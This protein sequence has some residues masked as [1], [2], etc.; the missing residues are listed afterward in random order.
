[1]LDVTTVDD[2]LIIR[3]GQDII[4]TMVPQF[5]A[6][7][8]DLLSKNPG[9][10]CL[11]LQNV[12]LMDSVGIGVLIAIHNTLKKQGHV[13]AISNASENIAKLFQTMRL[14]QHFQIM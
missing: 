8:V 6:Q 10:I 1:M 9:K 4:S 14:D 3:P 5:K 13:L 2:L 7:V 11:D 12:E